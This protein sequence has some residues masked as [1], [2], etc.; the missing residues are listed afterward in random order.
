MAAIILF[1]GVCNLCNGTVQFVIKHDPDEYFRFA[2]LQS[3]AG[4]G[5]LKEHDLQRSLNTV[6]LIEGGKF[7]EKSDAVLKIAGR[8]RGWKL[9][10]V[11]WILPKPIRDFVYDLISR[12]RYYWFGKRE[13]CMLPTAENKKR[14]LNEQVNN[15]DIK[16]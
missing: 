5:L 14:F 12:N 13:S 9:L 3:Q 1:D 16:N 10:S 7:Y 4:K 6:I 8:L 15:S 2:S 11:F